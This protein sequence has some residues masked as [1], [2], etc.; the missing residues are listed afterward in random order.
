MSVDSSTVEDID[1][2]ILALLVDVIGVDVQSAEAG[3]HG[4]DSNSSLS[5]IVDETKSGE[6]FF[7]SWLE[8][9]LRNTAKIHGNGVKILLQNIEL[10]LGDGKGELFVKSFKLIS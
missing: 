5:K 4:L 3:R 2:S 9:V 6:D 7:H 1:E 8:S 10:E